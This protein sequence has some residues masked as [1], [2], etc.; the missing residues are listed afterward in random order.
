MNN[1]N[2]NNNNNSSQYLKDQTL[3]IINEVEQPKNKS[4]I[5]SLNKIYNPYSTTKT[6][7]KSNKTNV[8][9]DI[10]EIE[11]LISKNREIEKLQ[12]DLT[13]MNKEINFLKSE[14]K[15]LFKR[16][17]TKETELKNYIAKLNSKIVNK[18][19]II[20]DPE[21][22][23]KQSNIE[24][25]IVE[26][27]DLIKK[28]IVYTKN[29]L[30]K[31]INN[32][33]QEA[34]KNQNAL[35]ASKIADQKRILEKMNKTR[36]EIELIRFDFDRIN[37]ECDQLSKKYETLKIELNSIEEDNFCLV[38]KIEDLKQEYKSLRK[39][40]ENI[41]LKNKELV[42]E[43]D[44]MFESV[45][46]EE[47]ENISESDKKS[48]KSK[49]K[50]SKKSKSRSKSKGRS[51]K[52]NNNSNS[53]FEN[54]NSS[55]NEFKTVKN[56]NNNL[57]KK[58][59]EQEKEDDTKS[60]DDES[61]KSFV[62]EYSKNINNEN[63]LDHKYNEKV[64]KNKIDDLSEEEIIDV[65]K[66]EISDLEAENKQ[67]NKEYIQEIVMKNEAQQL[68]QKCIEDLKFEL[69]K[70][71][72][73]ISVLTNNNARSNSSISNSQHILGSIGNKSSLG[74]ISVGRELSTKLSYRV[75]LEHKL[76]VM[77][78]VYDNAFNYE[79]F[80]KNKLLY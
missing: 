23:G 58:N 25:L 45:S 65:I 63:K 18:E 49:S 32:K 50:I 54:E 72:K 76:K 41:F 4:E 55:E 20:L 43:I 37:M 47:N 27:Q 46:N 61:L 31:E 2:N 78:F 79:L 51:R 6:F 36:E 33:F 73:D 80:K 17:N 68:M 3:P 52:D 64:L 75:N 26:I 12:I 8:K 7:N 22:D 66:K 62:D 38:Q 67:L 34:E 77:T 71:N 5:T 29:E 15:R 60:K 13:S 28:E 11:F 44:K 1:S 74:H 56:F 48:K 16:S 42:G 10:K 59:Q 39:E 40:H 30:E 57:L 35:M 21:I 14:I 53:D 19:T 70:V 24:N 69:V 9:K